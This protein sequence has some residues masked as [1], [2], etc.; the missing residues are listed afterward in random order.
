MLTSSDLSAGGDKK[1]NGILDVVDARR[2]VRRL[3]ELFELL[4]QLVHAVGWRRRH[5]GPAWD[6]TQ[7]LGERER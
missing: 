5:L 7:W 3:L 1:I 2:Q 6:V 4:Q